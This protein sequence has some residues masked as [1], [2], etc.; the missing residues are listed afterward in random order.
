MIKQTY[1]ELFDDGEAN[2][3]LDWFIDTGMDLIK[4]SVVTAGS[5]AGTMVVGTATYAAGVALANPLAGVALGVVGTRIVTE[6]MVRADTIIR[7]IGQRIYAFSESVSVLDDAN[8]MGAS[9]AFKAFWDSKVIPNHPWANYYRGGPDQIRM[10]EV[11]RSVQDPASLAGRMKRVKKWFEQ[12]STPE[13]RADLAANELSG[14]NDMKFKPKVGGKPMGAAAK[15]EIENA[16]RL[17]ADSID[18]ISAENLATIRAV[19]KRYGKPIYELETDMGL[20]GAGR[21]GKSSNRFMEQS[22]KDE[23]S[24]WRN[25]GR[26]FKEPPPVLSEPSPLAGSELPP[27]VSEPPPA[28]AKA[29]FSLG[30]ATAEWMVEKGGALGKTG[31]FFLEH[32]RAIGNVMTVAGAA[33]SAGMT[34]YSGYSLAELHSARNKMA[35]YLESHEHDKFADADNEVLAWKNNVIARKDAFFAAETTLTVLSFVP[36]P[37]GWVAM[38]LGAATTVADMIQDEEVR[39]AYMKD[40]LISNY[41]SANAPSFDFYLNKHD[42]EVLKWKQ[43]I[44]KKAGTKTDDPLAD[45]YWKVV[46]GRL[47]QTEQMVNAGQAGLGDHRFPVYKELFAA[48]PIAGGMEMLKTVNRQGKM[49]IEGLSQISQNEQKYINEND[50]RTRS[51]DSSDDT[52]PPPPAST[53]STPSGAQSVPV[54]DDTMRHPVVSDGSE[55]IGP[56]RPVKQASGFPATGP[57]AA[58][59][60]VQSTIGPQPSVSPQP[61]DSRPQ[62][63]S[64]AGGATGDEERMGETTMARLTRHL[65]MPVDQWHY[66]N[67][68]RSSYRQSGLVARSMLSHK[69][70][71]KRN[72]M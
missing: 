7:H 69:N 18:E 17:A 41:G 39:K 42:P 61:I 66:P 1:P 68:R 22:W 29:S 26:E 12:R 19:E 4:W 10:N 20:D 30:R 37:I 46:A 44:M 60:P 55:D 64:I 32:G 59:Q 31:E 48:Y 9:T 65:S 35:A 16:Q 2:K 50:G 53:T 47:H 23:A 52:K 51:A 45:S 33:F 62:A 57:A 63:D 54:V 38:G 13:G 67:V 56:S 14:V 49:T 11:T 24:E 70:S 28:G 34:I 72:R 6:G 27:V 71:L 43:E 8:G 5:V 36:G 3:L 21:P 40:F 25:G 15:G 58:Q